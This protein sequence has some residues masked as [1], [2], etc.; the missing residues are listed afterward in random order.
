MQNY[1]LQLE[2]VTPLELQHCDSDTELDPLV[3]PLA[4]KYS[5]DA[6]MLCIYV[7]NEMREN[8]S[9]GFDLQVT[10]SGCQWSRL[11]I[12]CW[13]KIK[14][15]RNKSCLAVKST[16]TFTAS[17]SVPMP[18]PSSVQSFSPSSGCQAFCDSVFLR[19]RCLPSRAPFVTPSL[20]T[21]PSYLKGARKSE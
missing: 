15:E 8:K 9:L 18:A 6:E 5:D 3:W 14:E 13:W 20:I 11:A 7:G 19:L 4:L 10:V 1:F 2:K 16:N 12:T 17:A 21:C